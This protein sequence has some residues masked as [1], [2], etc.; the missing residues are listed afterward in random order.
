MGIE[1][2]CIFVVVD[3]SFVVFVV[4][5]FFL[6]VVFIFWIFFLLKVFFSWRVRS[7]IRYMLDINLCVNVKY[8]FNV[9]WK[10]I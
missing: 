1:E 2:I 4:I 10:V 5:I 6:F 7:Y 3:I 8:I 9:Y